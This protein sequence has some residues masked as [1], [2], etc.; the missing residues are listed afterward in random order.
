RHEAARATEYYADAAWSATAIFLLC[1]VAIAMPPSMPAARNTLRSRYWSPLVPLLPVLLIASVVVLRDGK[2]SQALP[3]QFSPLSLAA[4]AAY[5]INSGSFRER[6]LV[7]MTP[8]TPLSRAI[9]LV[10]D[11]SIRA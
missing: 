2:G 11:E 7:S 9:V 6:E 1:L 8:G 4:V 5:K 3:M 10:V